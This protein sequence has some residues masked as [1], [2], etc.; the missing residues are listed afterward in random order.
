MGNFSKAKIFIW[1]SCCSRDI[2]NLNNNLFELKGYIFQK[3]PITLNSPPLFE[4]SV[5]PE[6]LTVLDSNFNR[7]MTAMEINKGAVDYFCLQ[8]NAEYLLVDFA[9]LRFDFFEIKR[10]NGSVCRIVNTFNNECVLNW[11]CENGKLDKQRITNVKIVSVSD[12]ELKECLNYF[13]D[14]LRTRFDERH[15]ILNQIHFTD[16]YCKENE[17]KAFSDDK[18]GKTEKLQAIIRKAETMF[19]ERLPNCNVIRDIDF[20]A[21]SAHPLGLTELHG[22]WSY[23]DYKLMAL[24]A[25]VNSNDRAEMEVLRDK[26]EKRLKNESELIRFARDNS[27]ASVCVWGSNV[28]REMFN[29]YDHRFLLSKYIY[30]NPMHTFYFPP[31]CSDPIAMERFAG[32]KDFFRNSAS[33]EFNK[34]LPEYLHK[35][36]G[37]YLVTD[38]CD[39]RFAFFE[40]TSENGVITRVADTQNIRNN[41]EKFLSDGILQRGN[42]R[43]RS[44]NSL[45]EEEKE[46]MIHE[47]VS[48]IRQLYPADHIIL[49]QTHFSDYYKDKNEFKY[50]E[51]P[52]N[53]N[54]VALITET[55]KRIISLMP[56]IYFVPIPKHAY[57]DIAH[58]QGL[59]R[60]NYCS[61][62][63]AYQQEV[64]YRVVYDK[65][66][67]S[68]I[69]EICA[70]FDLAMETTVSQRIRSDNA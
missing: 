40:I 39:L 20:Y 51:N 32:E 45:T 10:E 35:Y 43:L 24:D 67:K 31:I 33:L 44:V 62:V 8:N 54:T 70:K 27:V 29:A 64:L 56:E 25:I 46:N 57:S 21:D 36:R 15:I 23:Y 12:R 26:Y 50:F 9:D 53:Q 68:D 28:S 17:L 16:I 49:F 65:A 5:S 6:D 30:Q 19:L 63:Y 14:I 55:E 1:G 37:D 18:K 2:F 34:N 42:I 58:R 52:M 61:D 47:Y 66:N 11:L 41:L 22:S 69:A 3:P 59:N 7:R 60:C 38:I 48:L 13:I 4:N